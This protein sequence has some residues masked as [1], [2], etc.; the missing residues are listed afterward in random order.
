MPKKDRSRKK[1]TPREQRDLDIEIGFIEG[2]VQR[3]PEYFEALQALGDDYTRR[4][5]FSEG[6]Q[7]DEQ[8]VRLRPRDPLA[9]YNLACSYSLTEQFE[10]AAAAL[11]QALNLGY[12]DLRWLSKDPDLAEFRKHPLYKKIRTKLRSLQIKIT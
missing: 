5:N 2:V 11:E 12:R 4:G 7:I 6:L 3:D 1:L 10:F 9:H 8:L